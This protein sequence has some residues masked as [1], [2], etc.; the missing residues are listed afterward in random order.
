[1]PEINDSILSLFAAIGGVLAAG[2]AWRSASS[3]SRALGH[4]EDVEHRSLLRE[5]NSTL[6]QII[7]EGMSVNE[8]CETLKLDY[9]Q[10][11]SFPNRGGSGLEQKSI[12]AVE[13]RQIKVG[14]LQ[15][16]A[17]KFMEKREHL[18]DKTAKELTDIL[19]AKE[20]CLRHIAR[21]KEALTRE[22]HDI[23]Q[24]VQEYRVKAKGL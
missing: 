8:L 3:A 21:E 10:L 5:I 12:D 18:G 1:M 15:G 20:S 24:Q 9:K 13:S 14:A 17:L 16:K 19:V 23:R 7:A 2:A 11:F 22:M 6:Q 4:A